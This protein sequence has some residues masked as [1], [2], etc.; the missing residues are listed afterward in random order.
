[1]S[2]CVRVGPPLSWRRPRSGLVPLRS[3]GPE[4]AQVASLLRLWPRE[5][6][7]P[8]Q[9]P[10]KGLFATIVFRSVASHSAVRHGGAAVIGKAAAGSRAG[11]ARTSLGTAHRVPADG[12]VR[13]S[14]GASVVK[15][16][17]ARVARATL[18]GATVRRVSADRAVRQAQ[19][20]VVQEAGTSRVAICA[21]QHAA[22]DRHPTNR[23][24][25]SMNVDDAIVRP[26]GVEDRASGPGAGQGEI[27][28][29]S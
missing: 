3:P 2:A 18:S 17:P 8:L 13:D 25:C 6:T 7:G 10:P 27:H 9:L 12:A 11:A 5:V 28:V 22:R 29:V 23:H 4:R 16:R 21:T 26:R 19:H 1:M 24:R 20:A 15:A 14:Q